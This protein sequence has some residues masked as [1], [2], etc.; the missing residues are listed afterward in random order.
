[1]QKNNILVF[2]KSSLKNLIE[3]LPK[4]VQINKIKDTEL[5]KVPTPCFTGIKSNAKPSKIEYL[6][7]GNLGNGEA[8][9]L[10]EI[11]QQNNNLFINIPKK[12]Y[13]IIKNQINL[14]KEFLNDFLLN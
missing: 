2:K 13:Q 14:Y 9:L 4:I 3:F 10:A 8:D 7:L 11:Y 5:I 12:E 6:L 1:M